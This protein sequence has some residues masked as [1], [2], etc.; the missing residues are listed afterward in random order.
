[1]S[2][3][4]CSRQPRTST[5][6]G[7]LVAGFAKLALKPLPRMSPSVLGLCPAWCCCCCCTEVGR[8]RLLAGTGRHGNDMLM[9]AGSDSSTPASWSRVL[10]SA[11]FARLLLQLLLSIEL[12]SVWG[13]LPVSE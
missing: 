12:L 8:A 9:A 13:L 2:L 6:Q 4:R 10:S 5:L 11:G 1:M 3:P 7:L